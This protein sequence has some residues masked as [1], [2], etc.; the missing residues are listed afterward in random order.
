M[1]LFA[2]NLDG[3]DPVLIAD[4]CW[5]S[6]A[7]GLWEVDA[8]TLRIGVED[9][10]ADTFTDALAD[11]APSD[12]TDVESFELATR[13]AS[14]VVPSVDGTPSRTLAVRVPPTVF[15][16]GDHPTTAGCLEVLGDL[17]QPD[18][19]VLDVGCGSGMLALLAATRGARVT[20]IDID[21]TAVAATSHNAWANGMAVDAST[22][23]LADI[24][25]RYRVVVANI[26]AG[27]LGPVLDDLVRVTAHDGH[28]VVSGLLTEHWPGVRSAVSGTLVRTLHRSGW[29]TAALL[30]H[31]GR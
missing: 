20:A 31:R 23:P 30:P 5:Q 13:D 25:T 8:A 3:H 18:D 6:G 29:V 26:T 12:V 21:P 28:L 22:T 9:I 11:V 2:I 1:R 27:A 14:V 10:D 4:R 24:A 7:T 19:T 17:V 15:G 16:D